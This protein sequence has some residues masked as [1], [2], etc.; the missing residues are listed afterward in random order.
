MLKQ[1]KQVLETLSAILDGDLDKAADRAEI[2]YHG[3]WLTRVDSDVAVTLAVPGYRQTHSY[4]CGFVAGLMVL[5]T[6]RPRASSTVFYYKVS[7]DEDT[8]TSTTALVRALRQSNIG[9][10]RRTNLSFA[11]IQGAINDGF[12][13]ITCI[14][15][16]GPDHHARGRRGR[17]RC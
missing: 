8:G 1:A 9:V 6:F 5:H 13:V 2:A 17:A 10:S 7:P 12:P 16:G 4:T 15:K 11:G 3:Q 14:R